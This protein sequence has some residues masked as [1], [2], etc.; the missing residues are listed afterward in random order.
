MEG[1]LREEQCLSL[2]ICVGLKTPADL[3]GLTRSRSEGK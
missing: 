1:T 3:D 2:G